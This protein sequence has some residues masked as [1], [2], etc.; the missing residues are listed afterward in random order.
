MG[1]KPVELGSER[2]DLELEHFNMFKA[3]GLADM[4][5]VINTLQAASHRL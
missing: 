2:N 4:I 3:T 5:Y 1:V